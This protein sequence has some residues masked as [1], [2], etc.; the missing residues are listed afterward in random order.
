V[1]QSCGRTSRSVRN[2]QTLR[3]T[4]TTIKITHIPSGLVLAEGR[5]GWGITSFEVSF[6]IRKK[7]LKI[8]RFKVNYIPGLCLY[9]FYVWLGLRLDG[10]AHARS[11]G[12]MYWLPNPLFPFIAFRVALPG[13]HPAL[14]VQ[15]FSLANQVA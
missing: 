3:I 13:N 11:L 9:K 4:V 6:C 10:A 14:R 5:L 7:C 8:L 2:S 15:R 1:D 12:W